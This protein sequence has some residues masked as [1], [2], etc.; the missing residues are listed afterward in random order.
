MHSVQQDESFN[1]T[2]EIY[3]LIHHQK[4]RFAIHVKP[5][6]IYSLFQALRSSNAS[7]NPNNNPEY[8][9]DAVY[10][11]GRNFLAMNSTVSL[12]L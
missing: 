6:T 3:K 7:Y 5:N 12:L 2:Q 1:T 10:E 9:V 11:T 4:Y 8:S